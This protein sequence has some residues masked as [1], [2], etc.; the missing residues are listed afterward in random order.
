MKEESDDVYVDLKKLAVSQSNRQKL[1]AGTIV[2]WKYET[3]NDAGTL[4]M[5]VGFNNESPNIIVT[6]VLN[7][8]GFLREFHVTQLEPI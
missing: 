6:R 2:R 8:L 1:A 4:Y 3:S 7:N 5:V